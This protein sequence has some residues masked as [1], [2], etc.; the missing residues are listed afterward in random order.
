MRGKLSS[1]ILI[2]AVLAASAAC[3]GVRAGDGTITMDFKDA[4]VRDVLRVL[5]EQNNLN[6]IISGDVKGRVTIKLKNVSLEEALDS[7]MAVSG[8]A[9]TRTRNI[10]RVTTADSV[11]KGAI[12][13]EVL[14]LKN[15]DPQGV[16]SALSS[17]VSKDGSIKVHS[18]SNSV[19]VTD[20]PSNLQKI[21]GL[22]DKID[23]ASA[24]VKIE[25]KIVE[26]RLAENESLGIDWNIRAGVSGAARPITFPF[27]TFGRQH[28]YYPDNRVDWEYDNDLGTWEVTSDFPPRTRG[29]L[30]PADTAVGTFP[31][32]EKTD[33]TFG[34]LDLSQFSVVLELLE[35]RG[36]T[37]ILSNPRIV[38]MDNNEAEIVVGQKVPI[39]LYTYNVERGVWEVTGYS[40]EKIGITLLVT[41]HVS[42]E[43]TMTLDVRPRISDIVG[44]TGPNNERPITSTRE[45][46]TQVRLKSGQVVAIGG[47]IKEKTIKVD[48]RVPVL[49]RIPI[50]G[51]L[52][53]KK[54]DDVEK[55][56]LLIFIKAEIIK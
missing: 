24:Q 9:C 19:V 18:D 46:T 53:R 13:T 1:I 11:E 20:Y 17:A 38:A 43:D 56:D 3:P 50:L 30:N 16:Q 55:T 14:N 12:V 44:F 40:E 4:D 42:S 6:L 7:L 25:A 26:T 36:D 49:G 29:V 52:F 41:P 2:L 51:W 22:V 21:K 27:D 32:A 54:V 35:S 31:Y 23:V 5:A 39:P 48:K 10:I 28:R 15:I 33:F 34:R 47:L 8:F 45:A 37:K